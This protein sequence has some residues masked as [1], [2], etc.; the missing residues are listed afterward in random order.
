M[1]QWIG[2]V[3]MTAMFLFFAGPVPADAHWADQSVA[4]IVVGTSSV[5]LTVTVPSKLLPFGDR[6]DLDATT[7]FIATHLVLTDD[8]GTGTVQVDAIT[9]PRDAR[10]T[11]THSTLEVTYSWARPIRGLVIRYNVFPAGIPTASC[12]ATIVRDGTVQTFVFT[13]QNQVVDLRFGVTTALARLG[14]FIALGIEHIFTGYDHI[15]FLLTLL[16]LGGALRDLVKIVSAFTVAHSVTLSLAALNVI[17]LPGRWVESAIAL[18]I[19]VVAAE[20]VLRSGIN[21]DNGGLSR[22]ASASSTASGLPRSSGISP[23]R[24]PRWCPR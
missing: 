3:A 7:A 23:S 16:M 17:S 5:R 19:V 10:L 18:S 24:G 9:T 21:C 8:S 14:S 15:L 1:R 22:S 20:N 6:A 2:L 12:L 13:P 4:E 11:A